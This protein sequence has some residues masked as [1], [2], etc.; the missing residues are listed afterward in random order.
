MGDYTKFREEHVFK[1]VRVCVFWDGV[2]LFEIG[3]FYT[4]LDNKEVRLEY[5]TINN[6]NDAAELFNSWCERLRNNTFW[7]F[8]TPSL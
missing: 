4:T 8:K 2:T 3:V 5:R 7:N 6:E 1:R